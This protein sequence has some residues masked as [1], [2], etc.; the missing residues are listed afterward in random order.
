MFTDE[1]LQ[2][3]EREKRI[4]LIRWWNLSMKPALEKRAEQL[5]EQYKCKPRSRN[6]CSGC[7]AGTTCKKVYYQVK[8]LWD[9]FE[10]LRVYDRDRIPTAPRNR[11]T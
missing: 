1:E 11:K 6:R 9:G 5:E 4:R 7:D 8:K 10:H 2:Y 3:F